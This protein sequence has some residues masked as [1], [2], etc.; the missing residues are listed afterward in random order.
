MRQLLAMSSDL[1]DLPRMKHRATI[2][3][4]DVVGALMKELGNRYLLRSFVI[5][6][7]MLESVGRLSMRE[8]FACGVAL[9]A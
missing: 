9:F 1:G 7:R 2:L 6:L 4:I 8:L 5:Q 3:A